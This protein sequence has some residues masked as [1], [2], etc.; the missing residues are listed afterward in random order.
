MRCAKCGV[1]SANDFAFCGRAARVSAGSEVAIREGEVA[2]SWSVHPYSGS[3]FNLT[4]L[5]QARTDAIYVMR[6]TQLSGMSYR[7]LALSGE[8][9][10]QPL[11]RASY[12]RS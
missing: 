11:F 2:V 8:F 1:I 3:L 5:A 10:G 4:P 6:A 12:S 9:E 7:T